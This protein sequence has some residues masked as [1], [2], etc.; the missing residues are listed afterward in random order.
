[1]GELE[2]TTLED[3]QKMREIDS[4][5]FEFA[6][7]DLP[8]CRIEIESNGYDSEIE[9]W[10][11][12]LKKHRNQYEFTS[13][14]EERYGEIERKLYLNVDTMEQLKLLTDEGI[15]FT[16]YSG[17]FEFEKENE[18]MTDDDII[19]AGNVEDRKG[20]RFGLARDGLFKIVEK[21]KKTYI[22]LESSRKST[23]DRFKKFRQEKK[24][25]EEQ[26][27]NEKKD[28]NINEEKVYETDQDYDKYEKER[29]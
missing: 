19:W 26:E 5:K 22:F 15:N 20:T 4:E 16:E 18:E 12:F 8:K 24:Q 27:L 11:G 2:I 9:A 6:V 3:L 10:N 7:S 25:I 23:L 28:D 17:W 1:M 21:D 13:E 14:S 29:E